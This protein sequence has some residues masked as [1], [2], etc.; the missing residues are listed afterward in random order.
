LFG[1]PLLIN[2]LLMFGIF[3]GDRFIIGS[4]NRIFHRQIYSL[5]D[6]GVYSVAFGLTLVPT[7]VIANIASALW[8]PLLSR[9]QNIPT[10]FEKRYAV[11]CQAVAMIGGVISLPLMIC[12]GLFVNIIY[13]RSYA[14]ASYFIGWLAAMQAVR[15]IRVGPTLAAMS[16]GDN[17][18]TM[19]SN[20]L[21]SS[22]L[23]V[24]IIVAYYERSLVWICAA[25][26]LGEVLALGISVWRLYRLQGISPLFCLKPSAMAGVFLGVA[27]V[28]SAISAGEDAFFVIVVC[29]LLMLSFFLLMGVLFPTSRRMVCESFADFL[30][31]K[32][33]IMLK[34]FFARQ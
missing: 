1:W 17:R 12:G 8:L 7:L 14:A 15:I 2:G 32:S 30:V 16:K 9:V 33:Q 20:L 19:I 21:R 4:A 29:G 3:Q 27:A 25:G 18:N 23:G 5:T 22:A 26:F 28:F 10:E 6:L 13:G 24:A 34:P 11:C 31:W